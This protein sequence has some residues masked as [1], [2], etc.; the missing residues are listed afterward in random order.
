MQNFEVVFAIKRAFIIGVLSLCCFTS[1]DVKKNIYN[2]SVSQNVIVDTVSVKNIKLYIETSASMRGYVNANFAGSYPLKDVVP[3]M[4]TDLNNHFG[5]E[6][7]LI[8]ISDRQQKFPYSKDRFF[9]QLRSGSIFRG[10]SSKLQHIFS[11]VISKTEAG[12]VSILITDC[13]PDLGRVNTQTEGSKV[14]NHIYR[15]I[16]G[17]QSYSAAVFQYKSDFNGT[18]YYNR[19]N[20]DGVSQRKRPYYN[21]T[22]TNRPF[23]V[24]VFGDQLLVSK[25][26]EANKIKEYENAHVYNM[27]SQQIPSGILKYPSSGKISINTEDQSLLIKEVDARRPALYTIGLD[28]SKLSKVH[29]EKLLDTLIYE[30]DPVFM[31]ESVQF[32]IQEKEDLLSEDIA[33]KPAIQNASYTHFLQVRLSDFD[34]STEQFNI[35]I[36]N[37]E[38]QWIQ[39]ASIEDDLGMTV[40]DLENKTFGFD[41]ISNAFAKAYSAKDPLLQFKFTKQQPQ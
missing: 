26:L 8:T 9:E 35:N 23:Y 11:D 31:N 2:F 10:K 14:T 38:P 36:I 34:L 7:E 24:W 6:T 25:I 28:A 4:V 12:E 33:H 21:E 20:N 22:L 29:Q 41:F 16:A 19:N 18:Y 30:I 39:E 5:V 1:C 13:I 17:N 40:N 27:Q 3:I 37:N 32:L 15:T